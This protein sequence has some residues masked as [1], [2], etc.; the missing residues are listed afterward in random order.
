[1]ICNEISP[2]DTHSERCH[3][4]AHGYVAEWRNLGGKLMSTKQKQ[5]TLALLLYL[6]TS[7]EIF[8][9]E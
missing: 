7:L 4:T 5:G 3:R 2:T 8:L 1:M 6:E 9:G